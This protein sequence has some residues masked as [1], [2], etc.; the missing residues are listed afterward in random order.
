MVQVLPRVGAALAHFI[1]PLVSSDGQSAVRQREEA[2]FR[3]FKKPPNEKSPEQNPQSSEERPSPSQVPY[4]KI[5]SK[6]QRQASV[7]AS[8]LEIFEKLSFSRA[9]LGRWFGIRA[10]LST[11]RNQRKTGRFKKGAMLD[12][13]AE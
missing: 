7:T 8:F 3:K 5:V 1:A 4:L 9:S 10:Y 11:L 12:R 2:A 13:Q 6:D